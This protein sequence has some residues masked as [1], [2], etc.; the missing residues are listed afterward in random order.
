MKVNQKLQHKLNILK[1]LYDTGLRVTASQLNISNA[2]QY[3]IPLK[4]AG[5]ISRDEVPREKSTPYKVGFVDDRTREKAKEFLEKH[6]KLNAQTPL[7]ILHSQ[8]EAQGTH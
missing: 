2:N 1:L 5:L 7:N 4:Y 3:F 8:N 6:N